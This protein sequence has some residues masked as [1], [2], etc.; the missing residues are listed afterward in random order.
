MSYYYKRGVSNTDIFLCFC[1]E[2]LF[3]W[4]NTACNKQHFQSLRANAWIRG[5]VIDTWSHILN[6][7]EK[8]RSEVSPLRLLCATETTSFLSLDEEKVI[9]IY[10]T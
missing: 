4:N 7:N 9:L 8:L 10:F 3:K 1:S 5:T 2:K 6:D